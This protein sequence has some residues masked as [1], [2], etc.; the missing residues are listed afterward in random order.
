M[1][2]NVILHIQTEIWAGVSLAIAV[3]AY[4][5]YLKGIIAGQT[6][7]HAF[8][9]IIWSILASVAFGGQL[10][11]GA[12]GGAWINGLVALVCAMIAIIA[13]RKNE[14]I[15]TK[16]DWASFIAACLTIPVWILTGNPLYA[17]ILVTII[18]TLAF[19]PTFRKSWFKP[20]E[21]SPFAY[22]LFG[23][24]YL[25]SVFAMEK[26][27][28]TTTLYPVW[29]TFMNALFVVMISWRQR[30]QIEIRAEEKQ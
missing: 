1:K 22:I 9:W 2:E 13:L 14:Q 19:Y 23:L 16:G 3:C 11:A 26:I 15:I 17:I 25:T 6:R 8:S 24:Q 18:D 7:P 30:T 10:K 5:P 4:V 29:L 12:G 28:W 21:E 20:Y 27:N